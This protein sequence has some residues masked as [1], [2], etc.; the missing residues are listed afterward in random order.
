[1]ILDEMSASLASSMLNGGAA[2]GS[3]G[4]GAM[5]VLFGE[6]GGDSELRREPM[7]D[8]LECLLFP[9]EDEG[10]VE[11]ENSEE[12][13]VKEEEGDVFAEDEV[14]EPGLLDEL[15]TFESTD[16]RRRTLVCCECRIMYAWMS[17]VLELLVEYSFRSVASQNTPFLGL[18]KTFLVELDC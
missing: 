7:E 8:D 4:M 15:E 12:G 17:W 18:L 1:L 13:A 9:N 14:L 3:S 11:K 2:D 6:V 10:F 5:L 16:S